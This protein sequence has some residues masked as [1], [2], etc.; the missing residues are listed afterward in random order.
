MQYWPP[1]PKLAAA[2]SSSPG[3]QVLS[4]SDLGEPVNFKMH[5]ITGSLSKQ[6]FTTAADMV[7][8][9]VQQGWPGIHIVAGDRHMQWAA[10]AL[11]EAN[12]LKVL[13]FDPSKADSARA[14]R[15]AHCM[16]ISHL[17]PSALAKAG[18]GMGLGG[19]LSEDG[20]T[21]TSPDGFKYDAQGSSGMSEVDPELTDEALFGK[22]IDT[23]EKKEA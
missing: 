17:T 12:G 7:A 19:H 16:D 10:W 23:K 22:K 4:Y 6:A 9:A 14:K 8:L 3:S 18:P 11:A 21:F 13:G 1:L 20:K 5:Y 2:I 15:A